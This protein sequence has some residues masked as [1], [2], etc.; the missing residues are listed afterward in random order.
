MAYRAGRALCAVAVA[1]FTLTGCGGAVVT[2]PGETSTLRDTD[3]APGQVTAIHL[4]TTAGSVTVR[5]SAH[6]AKTTIHRVVRYR[7]DAPARTYTTK[8]GT[9]TLRGCG[10]ECS[11]EYTVTA[12]PGL[13]I[14]GHGEAGGITLAKVGR[15]NVTTETGAMEIDSA[16]GPVTTRTE[17]GAITV[18]VTRP[19]NVQA[20]TENGGVQ[21]TVPPAAY[22]V[23]THVNGVG[24]TTIGVR[25]SPSSRYTL[26][27]ATEN[28]NI[29][30][31]SAP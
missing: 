5:G 14:T 13:P 22:R 16:T 28:G 12:P 6:A 24:E 30:V 23:A 3:A 8:A 7:G 26:N 25:N 29:D 20:E 10:R 4:A 18:S 9:L 11:V 21:V 1:A 17:A 2:T 31:R 19:T 27:L 15:V